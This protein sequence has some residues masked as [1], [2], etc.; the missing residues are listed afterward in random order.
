[1]RLSAS[2]QMAYLVAAVVQISHSTSCHRAPGAAGSVVTQTPPRLDPCH[3]W[4]PCFDA[5]IVVAITPH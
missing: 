2:M 4:F 3:V 5:L 1:M